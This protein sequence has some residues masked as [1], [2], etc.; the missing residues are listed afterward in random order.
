MN[1]PALIRAAMAPNRPGRPSQAPTQLI[2]TRGKRMDVDWHVRFWIVAVVVA[3]VAALA[4]VPFRTADGV[5]PFAFERSPAFFRPG[6]NYSPP[7]EAPPVPAPVPGE[8]ARPRGT[9]TTG[10]DPATGNDTFGVPG[11]M[12]PAADWSG[13]GRER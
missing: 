9:P 3:I 12:P 10:V 8:G 2:Q 13:N 11:A 1:K 5:D 6:F 7:T 4:F